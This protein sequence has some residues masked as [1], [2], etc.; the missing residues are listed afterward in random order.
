MKTVTFYK[1]SKRN[2]C[3]H[4][5]SCPRYPLLLPVGRSKEGVD[6]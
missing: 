3:N 6:A 1:F 5:K 4:A 2:F